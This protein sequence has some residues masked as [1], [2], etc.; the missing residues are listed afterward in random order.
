MWERAKLKSG[1]PTLF[2]P[3]L[4]LSYFGKKNNMTESQGRWRSLADRGFYI[5]HIEHTDKNDLSFSYKELLG[6]FGNPQGAPGIWRVGSGK[7]NVSHMHS[8]LPVIWVGVTFAVADRS[9]I[10]KV[11]CQPWF[12]PWTLGSRAVFH[13]SKIPKEHICLPTAG[14]SSS[15]K[16][17][18]F[19]P[20]T[21]IISTPGKNT[22]MLIWSSLVK[23]ELIFKNAI[24]C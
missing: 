14:C 5:P 11:H 21:G 13:T 15:L 19:L 8:A 23:H 22:L 7:N 12:Q 10:C 20:W 2:C 17:Q 9:L 4:E 16:C 18:V 3:V 1:C 24:F 6:Y